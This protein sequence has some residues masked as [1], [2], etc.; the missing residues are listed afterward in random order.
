VPLFR[1]DDRRRLVPLALC[2]VLRTLI[3]DEPMD[4]SARRA[5]LRSLLYRIQRLYSLPAT[6]NDSELAQELAEEDGEAIQDAP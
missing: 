1:G 6:V 5:E 3:A 4:P 2:S